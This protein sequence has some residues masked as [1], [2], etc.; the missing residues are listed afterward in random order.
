MDQ[1]W[2]TK[3]RDLFLQLHVEHQFEVVHG[4]GSSALELLRS[5]VHERVPVVTL[6]HGNF[7]GLARAGLRR[8]ASS[9]TPRA[10]L[11]ELSG[12]VW[13]CGQHF[14]HGNWYR[15]RACEAMV[16]S[17]QQRLDTSRSHLLAR[18]RVHVVPNG[19]DTGV[20]QPVDRAETR[21]EL[22][23]PRGPLLVSVGRLSREKGVHHA[24]DALARLRS[25]GCH[26]SL[27][28]VG[29][30]AERHR[31]ERLARDLSVQDRTF[32]VGAQPI[33]AVARYLGAADI[34]VFPTERDEAAPLVLPQAMACGLPVVASRIGGIEE[35]IER[36]EPP[37]ILV[38]PGNCKALTET[39]ERLIADAGERARLGAS[40]LRL[41]RAE[42][43]IEVM[44][45][46]TLA[47]Y[48]MACGR[49]AN[50]AASVSDESG[51]SGLRQL[52]T[53]PAAR[54]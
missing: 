40:A 16:V 50:H 10:A 25:R 52:L 26:A 29:D 48:R 3:S 22:G 46:C 6:F 8:A 37:G 45:E 27:V 12:L 51:R 7:L 38:P 30:G 28:I 54:R 23:L 11:S 4:E 49:F 20:F 1:R 44:V 5:N 31:L 15:F 24:I 18:D 41:A 39:L 53:P 36:P 21:R 14:P 42:Y 17:H 33:P 13:L 43:S 9:R 2:R 35:V 32:F 19:I 34:F 47:V